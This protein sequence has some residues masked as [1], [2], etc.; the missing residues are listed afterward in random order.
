MEAILIAPPNDK[1]DVL[2]AALLAAFGKAQAQKDSELLSITGLGDMKPSALLRR[3]QSLNSNPT[4]LFRAHFLALL[5]SEVW[6]VLAGQEITDISD[7]AKAADRIM[8]ARGFDNHVAPVAVQALRAR[9]SRQPPTPQGGGD[10]E[11]GSTSGT[12]E[13]AHVC[14]YHV[15][16]GREARRCQP[17]CLLND[18]IRGQP[19]RKRGSG[20]LLGRPPLVGAVG[21]KRKNALAVWDRRSGRSYLVDTRADISVFPASFNDR[22]SCHNSQPLVA[23]NGSTIRTWGQQMITLYLG[24][25]LFTQDFHIADVTRPIFGA[26]FFRHNFL[27]IYVAGRRLIDLTRDSVISASPDS[28]VPLIA[29]LATSAPNEFSAILAEFP[30]LL[31]PCYHST[32]NKHGVEHHIVTEGHPVFTKPRRLDTE[33]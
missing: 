4:T 1:Y 8:E 26:D 14:L 13:S 32:E 21:T 18:S 16:Y 10:V 25:R 12:K 29:G 3:L 20:K 28:S 9:S 23:A 33:K 30:S 31:V 27:A 5:P 24:N 11:H 6:S 17:W 22:K 7:L 2:K 15:H 19:K